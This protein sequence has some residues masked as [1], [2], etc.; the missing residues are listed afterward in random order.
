MTLF[1]I[2]NHL[3]MSRTRLV[4]L[5]HILSQSRGGYLPLNLYYSVVHAVDVSIWPWLRVI[6]IVLNTVTPLP[7]GDDPRLSGPHSSKSRNTSL[8]ASANSLL[9][10][11]SL[12]PRSRRSVLLFP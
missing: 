11:S 9:S 4:S 6:S 8:P 7:D 12:D 3:F 2:T 10:R 5:G 1:H